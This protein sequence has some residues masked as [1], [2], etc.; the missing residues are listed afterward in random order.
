MIVWNLVGY[1]RLS[2]V[3]VINGQKLPLNASS[4]FVEDVIE[5]LVQGY[6]AFVAALRCRKV[7]TKMLFKV[8]F[9][10]FDGYACHGHTPFFW[11]AHAAS[12]YTTDGAGR[13]FKVAQRNLPANA[14]LHSC[15]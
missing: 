7:G 8:C 2:R 5:Y 6:L 15:G 4:Q 13:K 14:R 1:L 3:V 10:H 9:V 12:R 11:A